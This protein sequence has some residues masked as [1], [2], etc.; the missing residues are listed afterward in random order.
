MRY[1]CENVTVELTSLCANEPKINE[2][3]KNVHEGDKYGT[4]ANRR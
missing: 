1:T 2:K 3:Y 4:D